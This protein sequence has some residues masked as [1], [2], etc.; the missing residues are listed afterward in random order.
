MAEQA[1]LLK[2]HFNTHHHFNTKYYGA[3]ASGI[4]VEQARLSSSVYGNTDIKW[5]LDIFHS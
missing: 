3:K 5:G 1:S 2:D 4:F